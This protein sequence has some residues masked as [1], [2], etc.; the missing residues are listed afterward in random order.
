MA[1]EAAKGRGAVIMKAEYM[2]V[3]EA[4]KEIIWMK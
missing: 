2:A 1:V 4:D 3:E